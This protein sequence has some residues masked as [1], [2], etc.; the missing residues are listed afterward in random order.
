MTPGLQGRDPGQVGAGTEDT[1]LDPSPTI[2]PHPSGTLELGNGRRDQTRGH[3][4][5]KGRKSRRA[6]G[7][8]DPTAM[9]PGQ[10]LAADLSKLNLEEFLIPLSGL[11]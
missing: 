1:Q 7:S 2:P 5:R 10:A 6:G 8:T 11:V 9:E 4:P 3:L